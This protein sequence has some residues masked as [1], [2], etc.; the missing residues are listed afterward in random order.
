MGV[1]DYQS[2]WAYA[3][4][5]NLPFE[6]ADK[7]FFVASG[8][9]RKKPLYEEFCSSCPI[10]NFCL[11]YAIVHD[12]EGTWGGMT[13]T[14]RDH[15]G[16]EVRDRLT[17]EAKYQGWY[18]ERP[19]IDEL[20][21]QVRQ[22]QTQRELESERSVLADD[23]DLFLHA[24]QYYSQPEYTEQTQSIFD[25]PEV[26]LPKVS[27]HLDSGNGQCEDSN[28][29]LFGLPDPLPGNYQNSMQL[30]DN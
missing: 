24:P 4:C 1:E 13:K 6:E 18:E 12:E 29:S 14:Q 7:I 3:R 25:M 16:P 11:S 22:A 9:P 30:L 5:A 15:L 21:R 26:Q 17:V 27:Q 2:K 23:F 10:I 20:V 8:R 19:S 28:E